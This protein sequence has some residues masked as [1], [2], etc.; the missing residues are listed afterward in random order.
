MVLDEV[1]QG[2]EEGA[3]DLVL[4]LIGKREAVEKLLAVRWFRVVGAIGGM[5][6]KEPGSLKTSLSTVVLTQAGDGGA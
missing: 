4:Y 3:R 1:V 5:G 2:L 6:R